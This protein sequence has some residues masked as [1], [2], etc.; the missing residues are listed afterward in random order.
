M[1]LCRESSK[2]VEKSETPERLHCFRRLFRECNLVTTHAA[3][4]SQTRS[5]IRARTPRLWQDWTA[6][7]FGPEEPQGTSPP[8]GELSASAEIS[9][10]VRFSPPSLANHAPRRRRATARQQGL[11]HHF[12]GGPRQRASV[13]LSQSTP[14]F[15]GSHTALTHRFRQLLRS[16]FIFD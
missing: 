15:G 14:G 9:Y 12:L 3:L 4:S 10:P 11:P 2:R 13:Q 16:S 1:P 8:R 5:A 6:C 7:V